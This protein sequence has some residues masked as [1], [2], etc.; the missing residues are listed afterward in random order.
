[1]S[2]DANIQNKEKRMNVFQSDYGFDSSLRRLFEN[3]SC[4]QLQQDV[5][6]LLELGLKKGGYFVEFGATN[7]V[8]LSN[9]HLLEM[10]FDWIG[11]L[12][13]PA[14]SWFPAL[15]QNRNC[16]IDHRAV[17]A[18]SGKTLLF[19]EPLGAQLS[20][21]DTYSDS[22][23]H[24]ESRLE[25]T[26]YQVQSITLEELLDSYG[27]PETIDFLSI[28]TE[29]SELDILKPFSFDRYKFRVIVCEHNFSENRSQ[30]NQLLLSHGYIQK[31]QEISEF[32]DW[33]VLSH[34]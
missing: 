23:F 9:T 15:I 3:S 6:A 34:A 31:Y 8:D 27:A 19:N 29:G 2:V 25:G 20:T 22:D 11:I 30:I 32:D 7:G 18:Q 14:T 17:W 16:H 28:D 24:R 4:G 33:Y 26:K 1:M 5:F 21:I 13:E 12:A 10:E